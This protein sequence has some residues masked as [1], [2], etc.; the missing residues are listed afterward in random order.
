MVLSDNVF[1]KRFVSERQCAA[2]NTLEESPFFKI[3]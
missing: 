2:V 3:N 1:M